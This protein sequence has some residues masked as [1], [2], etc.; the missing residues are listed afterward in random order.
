MENEA[1][2]LTAPPTESVT[3]APQAPVSTEPNAAPQGTTPV[4]PA[5]TGSVEPVVQTPV[6][7][8]ETRPKPKP[9]EFY[10]QRQ[11]IQNLEKQLSEIQKMVEA[12]KTQPAS[13]SQKQERNIEKDFYEKPFPTV[14]EMIDKALD[15]RF[16]SFKSEQTFEQKWQTGLDIIRNSEHYKSGGEEAVERFK[17]I[18]TEKGGRLE[19]LGQSDPV[20]AAELAV[21]IYEK[22]Y[23]KVKEVPK[24]AL[25]PKSKAQMASTQTGTPSAPHEVKV[26]DLM[27]ELKKMKDTV[28]QDTSKLQDP[29]YKQRVQEIK[30]KIAELTKQG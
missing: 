6:S 4:Q 16:N 10:K 2:V 30:A 29:A 22:R 23:P 14:L 8:D 1:S 21:E 12:N 20:G 5:A 11:K 3:E 13:P 26:E 27:T 25:A 9:S 15:Q 24:T 17:E 18:L 19:K 7:P 28:M